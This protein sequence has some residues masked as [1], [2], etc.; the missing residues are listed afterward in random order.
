MS[1]YDE[2][3]EES[4]QHKNELVINGF[5]VCI[6]LEGIHDDGDDYYWRILQPNKGLVL[7][8][9]VMQPHYLKGKIDQDDYDYTFNLFKM[10]HNIWKY[11]KNSELETLYET[12]KN[13]LEKNSKEIE[14]I[15]NESYEI[16]DTIK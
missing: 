7:E 2:L 1:T 12:R 14:D 15:F 11:K 9:C 16:E 6:L 10:N 13:E 8:S 3:V 4:K 5:N